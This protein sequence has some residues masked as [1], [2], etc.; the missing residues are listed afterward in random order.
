M[1]ANANIPKDGT[2][3]PS[4]ESVLGYHVMTLESG[5]TGSSGLTADLYSQE[6]G[7]VSEM[8]IM[9]LFLFHQGQATGFARVRCSWIP[10]SIP[11][12]RKA[13]NRLLSALSFLY[14]HFPVYL[15]F[16]IHRPHLLPTVQRALS[17]TAAENVIPKAQ[18]TVN[19]KYSNPI[20]STYNST[21]A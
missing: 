18:S 16:Y 14:S 8:T 15:V 7:A 11:V 1:K 5:H 9:M 13:E 10:F 19:R 20:P 4:T 17:I 21:G 12:F 3:H 6:D 2:R